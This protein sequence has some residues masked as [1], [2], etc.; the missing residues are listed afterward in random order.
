MIKKKPPVLILA[1]HLEYPLRNG[2][3][4][5]IDRIGCHLSNFR[6]LIY[7]LG[8]NTLTLYKNGSQIDQQYFNN[9][10]RLKPIAALRT[11]I[12]NS[13]YLYEKFI[14][15]EY[16]VKAGELIRE[17]DKS[18]IIYSFI[19]SA[20]LAPA[21]RPGIILTHNNEVHWFQNQ[22]QF[23]INPFHK[24]TA[25]ISK[26]WTMRFL[27]NH[28]Q[29]FVYVHITKKD[30]MDYM[31]IIPEHTGFIV[32]AGVEMQ[33]SPKKPD[34]DGKFRLLFCGALSVKMNLDALIFFKK[35]FWPILHDDF[36]SEIEI[37]I[38]GSNPTEKVRNLC[39]EQGWSL[40]PDIS[41]KDLSTLYNQATFSFLPFPYTTGSKLKLLN[42]MAAGLPVLATN[43]MK[44]LPG[45]DFQ[46][47]LYSDDPLEWLEHL[48][49]Y[50]KNS[51]F[52]DSKKIMKECQEFVLKYSWNNIVSE[53]NRNLQEMGL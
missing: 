36:K 35:N 25:L 21:D 2:A 27:R 38:A 20:K 11:L 18:L 47:N 39:K 17:N 49:K 48:K 41:D 5:Y 34:W 3:D 42:A 4:I 12:L 50:S 43:N 44:I 1:P 33:P 52:R 40:M 19:S 29:D 22:I 31:R 8:S 37:L 13:H 6:E 23:S 28:E 24:M 30:Y 14:T 16:Q 46:P 15:K 45:Q 7:I 53:F 10:F 26:N 9:Q 32:P 51:E